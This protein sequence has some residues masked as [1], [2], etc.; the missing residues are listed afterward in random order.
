M[1]L[2]LLVWTTSTAVLN[3]RRKAK[4]KGLKEK[5][6]EKRGEK[7]ISVSYDADCKLIVSHRCWKAFP[8]SERFKLK[9]L[10]LFFPH[11]DVQIF[12][13]FHE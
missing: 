10:L 9:T 7:K 5:L 6:E 8:L 4:V 13:F 2:S 12:F 3:H 1:R 11:F